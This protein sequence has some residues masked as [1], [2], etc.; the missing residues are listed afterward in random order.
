MNFRDN[1]RI[2]AQLA[3]FHALIAS[4][5][6]AQNFATELLLHPRSSSLL[7]FSSSSDSDS[8]S[9]AAAGSRHIDIHVCRAVLQQI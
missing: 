5:S 1:I 9:A 2:P 8:D 7:L 6:A 4:L 3:L